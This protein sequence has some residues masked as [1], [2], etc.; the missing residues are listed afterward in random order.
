MAAPTDPSELGHWLDSNVVPPS[1]ALE[2]LAAT[3][4]ER[5]MGVWLD[6]AAIN[7]HVDVIDHLAKRIPLT[8]DNHSALWH[9]VTN[10]QLGAL[11]RLLDDP[12]VNPGF[13]QSIALEHAA[14]AGHVDIVRRLLYDS[15]VDPNVG[16]DP[17][18]SDGV[19]WELFQHPDFDWRLYTKHPV[20]KRQ[21]R[22]EWLDLRKSFVPALAALHIAERQAGTVRPLR[23]ERIRQRILA[24]K[25]F[26]ELCVDDGSD[27]PRP[28]H[29][30]FANLI[31]VSLRHLP[32]YALRVTRID[33]CAIIRIHLDNWFAQPKQP[34]RRR[35]NSRT[36]IG[37]G[38]G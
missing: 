28:A 7:G 36:K 8:Y 19:A 25:L 2:A 10:N 24:E 33:L 1:V 35:L 5:V 37:D 26:R 32:V 17:H 18:M 15:R 29:Y 14:T 6:W 12:V 23:E 4:D 9:A 30:H 31:G 20:I 38:N 13:E 11:N 27:I 3:D 16:G 34:K 21:V 22:Q